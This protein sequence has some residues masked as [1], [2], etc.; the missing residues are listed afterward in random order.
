MVDNLQKST[1][2]EFNGFKSKFWFRLNT[3]Q[4]MCNKI[5]ACFD[6]STWSVRDPRQFIMNQYPG[7]AV[8]SIGTS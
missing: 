3:Y 1:N 6:Y 8:E 5:D 4:A 7:K 2:G